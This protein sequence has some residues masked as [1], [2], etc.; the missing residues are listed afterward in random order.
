MVADANIYGDF[1]EVTGSRWKLVEAGGRNYRKLKVS[2]E[3][4]EVFTTSMEAPTTSMEGPINLHDKEHSYEENNFKN[5]E[6]CE[7]GMKTRRRSV[8]N[9]EINRG[10]N[11]RK[12]HF[13]NFGKKK[14]WNPQDKKMRAKLCV[15]CRLSLVSRVSV[16][17]LSKLGRENM[18]LYRIDSNTW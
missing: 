11:T 4:M 15:S 10:Q 14:G 2:A 7:N 13:H 17:L 9:W 18:S 3:S 5:R 16:I 12:I 8:T 1:A 6:K